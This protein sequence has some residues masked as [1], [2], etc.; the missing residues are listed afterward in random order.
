LPTRYVFHLKHV[1]ITDDQAS[2]RAASAF[3]FELLVLG[4]RDT[5]KLDQSEAFG[6]VEIRAKDKLFAEVTV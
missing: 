2:R 6:D 3:F 1:Y 4:T 5:I